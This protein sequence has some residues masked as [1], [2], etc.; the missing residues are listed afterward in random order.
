MKRSLVPAVAAAILA[1]TMSVCAQPTNRRIISHNMCTDQLL[2]DLALP[3]QIVGLSPYA[4]N[5]QRSY[6]AEKARHFPILSG[7]AEDIV[8]LRPDLVVTGRFSKRETRA[9]LR[10]RNMPMEEFDT[11]LSIEDARTQIARFGMITGNT[12][13]A[14]QRL[15]EIDAALEEL[16]AAATATRLAILPLSR[17][18]WVSGRESLVSDLL[19][20]AGLTNAAASLGFRFGGFT[21]LEAIVSLKPDA[22]LLSRNQTSAED[23]GEAMLL[24]PALQHLFP[25]ERRLIIPESLTVCGGP[26]LADAMRTF[27]RQIRNLKPRDAR[28]F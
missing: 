1:V 4:G 9:F 20:Q 8:A 15:A 22:V 14:S 27:A 28:A 19:T 17:R 10:A 5:A 25:P 23:Q 3:G 16:R 11:V 2:L 7:T 21:N 6:F 13:K 26:M 18:A 24:H 12:A